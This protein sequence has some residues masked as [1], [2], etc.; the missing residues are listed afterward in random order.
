MKHPKHVQHLVLVGPVGFTSEVDHKSEWLTKSKVTWK[1]AVMSHLWESNFTPVKVL[2]LDVWNF[3]MELMI[4]KVTA[5]A[6][7]KPTSAMMHH[8]GHRFHEVFQIK[9]D[10]PYTVAFKHSKWDSRRKHQQD[11]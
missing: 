4:H 3:M 1:G 2:S 6:I 5:L 10:C 8:D 9:H 11:E 7:H